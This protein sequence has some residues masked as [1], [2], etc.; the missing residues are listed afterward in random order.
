MWCHIAGA[1]HIGQ[2]L[3]QRGQLDGDR[4]I[5][6]G[7]GGRFMLG[8]VAQTNQEP[9]D[10]AGGNGVIAA[11]GQLELAVC[12]GDRLTPR[13]RPA[14]AADARTNDA[15]AFDRRARRVEHTTVHRHAGGDFERRSFVVSCALGERHGRARAVV[16]QCG[17][18]G[19]SAGD[20]KRSLSGREPEMITALGVGFERAAC[21]RVLG[22]IR[23]VAGDQDIRDRL[24]RPLDQDPAFDLHATDQLDRDLGDFAG[25]QR[26]LLSR[27]VSPRVVRTAASH[28]Y[29]DRSLVEPVDHKTAF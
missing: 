2:L 28:E 9:G 3:L 29:I 21:S 11:A 5:G 20:I 16:G 7:N 15:H 22:T 19:R 6:G 14:D 12:I 8:A 26:D 27:V 10:F 23:F 25:S 24:L 1:A 13:K 18:S 4:A 17:E